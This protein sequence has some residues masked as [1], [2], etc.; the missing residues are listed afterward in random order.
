[1]SQLID[2]GAG[3]VFAASVDTSIITASKTRTEG[4]HLYALNWEPGPSID[5][6]GTIFRTHGFTMPQNAL[7]AEGWRLASP[8]VLNLLEKLRSTG[9][10]LG[11]YV[12]GRFYMG[13]KTGLN[14]AFVVDK[15][16]WDKLIAEH[17]SSAKVLKPFLRGRDVKRW[18]ANHQDLWLIF[19]RRGTNIDNYP[20]IKK[21]LSQ[22]RKQLEPKPKHL[23]SNKP[24]TGRKGGSYEWYEIQDNIA[25][26][27]EFDQSIF[28]LT[29][30]NTKVS[31][32]IRPTFTVLI[33]ATLYPQRKL[34]YAVYSIQDL[35]NG[36]IH[37]CQTD[38]AEA[39]FEH[40]ATI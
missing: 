34:G 5:E 8:R 14:E 13:I 17:P 28:I 38:W 15:E 20:A 6:L 7:T 29:C 30:S 9:T 11:E 32:L 23:P 2:F 36:F 40:S 16:T 26:W 19:T 39:H 25:Y 10:P 27:Q 3:R 18:Q 37:W 33:P 22:Y 31:Q 1:M 12:K 35:W 24:W 21:H 4:N